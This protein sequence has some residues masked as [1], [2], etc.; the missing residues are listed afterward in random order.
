MQQKHLNA[1]GLFTLIVCAS[2]IGYY[3]TGQYQEEKEEIRKERRMRYFKDSLAAEESLLNLEMLKDMTAPEEPA[4][5]T[6]KK[7]KNIEY[8]F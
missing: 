6:T 7:I 8:K 2:L 5:D 3:L 1:I 4:E